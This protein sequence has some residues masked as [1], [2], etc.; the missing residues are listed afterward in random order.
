MKILVFSDSHGDTA[1]LSAAAMA[2]SPD[3]ILHLGD[4][5]SDCEIIRSSFPETPLKAVKGNGDRFS[6]ASERA[7]FIAEGKRM[8]MTHGHLYRVKTGLTAVLYAAEEAGADILLFGHT[9][10]PMC[11]EIGGI[12]VINP[13]AAGRGAKTYAVLSIEHGAASCEIKEL[14]GL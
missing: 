1:A 6:R 7:E 10:I 14:S 5:S 8:M 4:Y 3:M 2:E 9:H 11:E 13:G 12:L